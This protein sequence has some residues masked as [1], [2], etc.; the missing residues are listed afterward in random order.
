MDTAI[1]EAAIITFQFRFLKPNGQSNPFIKKEGSVNRDGLILDGQ[2]VFYRDI[3]KVSR[4]HNTLV[5]DMLPFP[6]LGGGLHRY[7]VEETSALVLKIS[8][9]A[10][11]V[12]SILN[13]R[14]SASRIKDRKMGM[15][16][17]EIKEQFRREN[18]PECD[19]AIDLTGL[20]ETSYVYCEFCSTIFDHYG[21]PIPGGNY[22]GICPELNIYDRLD[23]YKEHAFYAFRR[24]QHSYVRKYY[25]GDTFAHLVI[26]QHLWKNLP[27]LFGFFGNL[28]QLLKME[29]NKFPDYIQLKTANLKALQGNIREAEFFYDQILHRIKGHPGIFFNLGM[30]HLRA[31]DKSQALHFFEKSLQVCSNYGP[32]VHILEKYRSQELHEHLR[33]TN[34]A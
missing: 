15:A 3:Y 32:T 23:D 10:K 34:L 9:F 29:R 27:Y 28:F 2:R 33:H 11:P 13:R 21:Y 18:C 5:I 22:Y 24:Q 30:A 25:C 20:K 6:A 19:A 31:G 4:H 7:M 16:P 17:E 1:R 26:H 8:G 14:I 12:Q